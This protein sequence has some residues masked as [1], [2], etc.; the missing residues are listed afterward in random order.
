MSAVKVALKVNFWSVAPMLHCRPRMTPN[1]ELT[2]VQSFD[3]HEELKIFLADID[4]VKQL[5]RDNKIIQSLHVTAM[6]YALLAL[7]EKL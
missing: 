6:P 4:E 2:H 3:P 7:E 1:C 5:I